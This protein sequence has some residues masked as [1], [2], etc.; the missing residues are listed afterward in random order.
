MYS[1]DVGSAFTS[2]VSGSTSNSQKSSRTVLGT[3]ERGAGSWS[4]GLVLHEANWPDFNTKFLVRAANIHGGNIYD[5]Q[6]SDVL[7]SVFKD[8]LAHIPV[9]PLKLNYAVD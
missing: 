2:R 5:G 4:F 1:A 8:S 9:S 3:V 7:C 6:A